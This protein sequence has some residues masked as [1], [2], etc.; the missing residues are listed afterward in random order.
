MYLH[1]L[2]T[3]YLNVVSKFLFNCSPAGDFLNRYVSP[4]LLFYSSN[5]YTIALN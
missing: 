4:D 2:L 1:N 5:K 3:R